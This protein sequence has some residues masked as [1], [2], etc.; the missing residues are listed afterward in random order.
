MTSDEDKLNSQAEELDDTW[1]ESESEA[2]SDPEPA[3]D[4]QEPEPEPE[5]EVK[6]EPEPAP[7]NSKPDDDSKPD[8]EPTGDPRED[9]IQE[10]LHS[11]SEGA[12]SAWDTI[13]RD[14]PEI[15]K[16][17]FDIDAIISDFNSSDSDIDSF[18]TLQRKFDNPQPVF[19][20]QD[21]DKELYCVLKLSSNNSVTFYA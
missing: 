15:T 18:L 10:I 8:F 6:P 17:T 1:E 20:I 11:L 3:D 2:D 19:T 21:L 14:T 13:L 4:W 9:L 5:P 16:K 7:T 12:R